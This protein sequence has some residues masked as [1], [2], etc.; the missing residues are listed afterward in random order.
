VSTTKSGIPPINF[1][2]ERVLVSLRPGRP[3]VR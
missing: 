2:A 3:G 1:S